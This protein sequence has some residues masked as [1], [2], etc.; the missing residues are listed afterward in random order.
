MPENQPKLR[1][2]WAMSERIVDEIRFWENFIAHWERDHGV[3]APA[4]AYDALSF[5]RL[6]L[7][8]LSEDTV[9]RASDSTDTLVDH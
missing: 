3:R 5:A 8:C 9:Q 7:K 4:R 2:R 1:D 6:R